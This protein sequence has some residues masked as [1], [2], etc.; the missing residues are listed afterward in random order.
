METLLTQP[1]LK[2]VGSKVGTSEEKPSVLLFVLL[3]MQNYHP[4]LIKQQLLQL[5]HTSSL[6]AASLLLHL[7]LWF[8]SA[9]TTSTAIIGSIKWTCEILDL[10]SR[11]KS[12]SLQGF[13][14][15]AGIKYGH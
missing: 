11:L 15:P 13:I 2:L 5:P 6:T 3:L 9:I 7:L 14:P 8:L 10:K 1:L 12:S 4:V